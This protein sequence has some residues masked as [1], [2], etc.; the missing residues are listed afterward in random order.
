MNIMRH[1]RH[2]HRGFTLIEAAIATSVVGL[3]I[4]AM[5]H[6]LA[7]G[8]QVNHEGQSITQAVFLSQQI[9]EWTVQLPFDD[10]V[11]LSL[12]DLADQTYSPP[13]DAHGN[14]ITTMTGWSQT[15]HLDWRDPDSLLTTVPKG[16]TPKPACVTVIITLDGQEVL[17]TSWMAMPKELT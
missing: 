15:I 8:T 1:N 10:P 5:V 7:V 13:R 14:P 17:R 11:K 9:R 16:T 3:G 2:R 4:V 12:T 6:S